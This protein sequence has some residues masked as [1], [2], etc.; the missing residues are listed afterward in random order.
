MTST[1]LEVVSLIERLHRGFLGAVKLELDN[2]EIRD[3][4]SVQALMLFNIGDFKMCIGELTVSGCYLGS[5]VSYNL[6][7]LVEAGYLTQQRSADDRRSTLVWLSEKGLG[8]RDVLSEMLRW[9]SR[10]LSQAMIV[11]FDLE[12]TALTLRRMDR[13]WLR[14]SNLVERSTR[15][16]A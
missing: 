15:F 9:H 2:R 12:S 10:M 11:E 7:K 16:A 8:L 5:N 4:T 1:Y 6:R 3:I 14:A 13:L